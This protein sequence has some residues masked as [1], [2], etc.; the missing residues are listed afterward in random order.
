[1]ERLAL[2][3][4]SSRS[5]ARAT[6]LTTD[7]RFPRTP[8]RAR[9]WD[10]AR[11]SRR[12]RAHVGRLLRL[13]ARRDRARRG[14]GRR[15]RRRLGR[16]RRS[17]DH[18][19]SG[20]RVHR[21]DG[22]ARPRSAAARSR[23]TPPL[24][25]TCDACGEIPPTEA[26]IDLDALDF[27]EGRRARHRRRAGCATR[28]RADGRARRSRGARAIARDRRDALSLAHARSVAQGRD[29]RQRAA[30]RVA[31]AD[32][33]GDA[34]LARVMPAGPACHT[35]DQLLPAA[36]ADALES[37]GRDDRAP[38]ERGGRSRQPATRGSSARTGTSG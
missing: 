1:M 15:R 18:R 10:A 22:S 30:R 31:H 24:G 6:V 27:D 34:V 7:E 13:S 20:R 3:V 16:R 37:P 17:A 33:D 29:E 5:L 11:G 8:D 25:A 26:V 14:D 38:L 2:P 23:P 19:R 9:R 12:D 28:T 35:G 36:A 4:S 21:L 32:C